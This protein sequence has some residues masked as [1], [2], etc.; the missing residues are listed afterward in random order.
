VGRTDIEDAL[1][2]LDK[3]T[4]DEVRMAIAQVL[5]LTHGVD[6]KVT[7]VDDGV[8]GVDDKVKVV[9]DKV[10]S[11][12]DTVKLVL[13][14]GKETKVIV[15]E[16][17]AIMQL[18]ANNVDEA[19]RN[20]WRHGLR[21]W[22]SSPDPSTNHIISCGAQHAGSAK[23]FFRGSH[24]EEWKSIGSLLWIHGKRTSLA[25]PSLFRANEA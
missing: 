5:K 16:A 18:M 24:F 1:K 13:D 25:D 7:R 15:R 9:D 23:W 20:Q 11:V 22:L 4:Q 10:S 14:D 2:R 3:L 17:T 12:S 19:K 8:K 21:K 6:D